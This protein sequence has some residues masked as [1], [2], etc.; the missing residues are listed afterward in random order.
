MKLKSRG[1]EGES[2]DKAGGESKGE[3]RSVMIS[4]LKDVTIEPMLLFMAI[5]WISSG[6]TTDQM[7]FYKTC[8]DPQFNQ[9]QDFCG[10]IEAFYNTTAGGSCFLH[11]QLE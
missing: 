11:W 6:V 7:I 4:F 8:M 2:D 1:K 9:T 5:G 3:K 10:D